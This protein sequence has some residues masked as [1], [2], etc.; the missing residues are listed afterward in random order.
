MTDL[1]IENV[2]LF[3]PGAGIDAEARTLAIDGD[4]ITSL[5][6]T[7]GVGADRVIDGAGML[8]T[9]GFVD[10]RAHLGEPGHTRAETIA[11]GVRA[12]ARGGFTTVLAMP[13]TEPTT[14]RVELVELIC[15]RARAA[16]PTNVLPVGALSVGRKGERL[17]EMAQL[18]QAGCVAFSDGDRAVRDSQLLRYAFELA[19][20]LGVTVITHAEDELLSLGGVMH[21]G[22]VSARLGL[23]GAPGTAE[24]VGVA[25][26]V[27]IS[28]LTGARVHIGHVSTAEAVDLIRD[29]K[30]KGIRVT[31]EVSPL[32]LRLTD[33]AVLGYD[34][35][36]K[37][38]PPLRPASDVEAVIAGLADGTIDCVASDHRPC[39]HLEKN[40]EFDAAAPGA[41]ALETTASVVLSLVAAQRLT[42]QRAI[43]TLTWGPATAIGHPELG[44]LAQGGRADLVLIDPECEWLFSG[45]DIASRSTNTPLLGAPM[46]GR[47]DTTIAGGKI[48]HTRRESLDVD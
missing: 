43:A 31:A 38:F 9:P 21:E 27:A 14:D 20:E 3:D 12:A 28:A 47:I 29:A 37:V 5:H 24:A 8:C 7:A 4:R 35:M 11:T 30:K 18:Q 2:R 39:T 40:L 34:T 26:D 17:S 15:A 22:V 45:M 33:E 36:A 44:R 42:L 13:T 32:H 48:T 46:Y 23:R 41:I 25:R 16:G 19:S 10:L 6:A 1:V